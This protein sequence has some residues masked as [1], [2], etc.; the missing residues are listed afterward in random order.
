MKYFF[1]SGEVSGDLHAAKVIKALKSK[2]DHA[3]VQ[4][5]GGDQM[6]LAGAEIKKHIN[7]LAFM[8]FAEVVK[9]LPKIWKN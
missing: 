8:G 9:N 7:E 1:V 6:A 3:E 2:D 5:W 4:A